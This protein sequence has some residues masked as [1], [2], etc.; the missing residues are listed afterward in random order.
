M[1]SLLILDV[2]IGLAMIYAVLALACTAANELVAQVA[3]L[4]AKTLLKGIRQL[5]SDPEISTALLKHPLIAALGRDGQA[6]K[7]DDRQPSYL[8]GNTFALALIDVVT[9]QNGKLDVEAFNQVL[10]GAKIN[11][12]LRRT[13]T[14]L[15]DCAANKV[16]QTISE[17][18]P[19]PSELD[20]LVGEITTWYDQ[21]TDRFSG[22]YKRQLQYITLAIA[23]ILCGI[24]NADTAAI[25]Q[26]LANNATLRAS[27]A[28]YAEGYAKS[29]PT[30]TD[31]K[32][33]QDQ[34]EKTAEAK[35]TQ[36]IQTIS[37]TVGQLD[38]LGIPLGWK[39]C[40]AGFAEWLLKI[41]GLLV[42]ILA[43]SLGAP[44]WF[45]LLGR[46]VN[47]RAAGAAPKKTAAGAK[48]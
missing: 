5:V 27:V 23:A 45:D 41:F 25:T 32:P 9:D 20:H 39:Q 44:F 7:K 19:K 48:T 34:P 28:A 26:A 11:P 31:A 33:A 14:L 30:I 4:R 17:K 21:A 46:F 24:L 8:P 40:P 2:A 42:T 16:A 29:N 22:W 37:Q 35:I 10:Q 1:P 47:I 12:E 6:D 15:S 43:V 13:L 38:K 18:S 3:G 36:D